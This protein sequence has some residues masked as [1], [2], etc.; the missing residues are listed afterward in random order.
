MTEGRPAPSTGVGIL[1]ATGVVT[2]VDLALGKSRVEATAAALALCDRGAPHTRAVLGEV[3][4]VA[5][6]M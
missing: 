1:R 6:L 2:S 4:G 5:N 3:D